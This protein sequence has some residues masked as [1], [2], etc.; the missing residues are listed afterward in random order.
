MVKRYAWNARR[1][2]GRNVSA[3]PPSTGPSVVP[4]PPTST[5]TRTLND[6][7][8]MNDSGDTFFT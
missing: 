2:S 5:E 8:T 1:Y 7:A 3:M 4:M 6:V